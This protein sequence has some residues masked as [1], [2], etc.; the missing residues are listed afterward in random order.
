[1]ALHFGGFPRRV[2]IGRAFSAPHPRSTVEDGVKRE[3]RIPHERGALMEFLATCEPGSPVAVETVGNWYWIVD[4]IEEAG[5]EPR[6]VHAGK[7][8]LMLGMVNKTDKLDARG[9]NKLQRVGTLPVVWIPPGELRDVRELTR[10]RMVLVS[11]RTQLKNR[12]HSTLD[13]YGL[14]VGVSDLFGRKGR[15]LLERK[16][17]KLPPHTRQVTEVMLAQID[18]LE[19]KIEAIE[20]RMREVL[21]PRREVGLLQT[22]PGVGFILA[23]VI[24][25]EVGEVG[26]FPG[27]E[28]LASYAGMVP[29]VH[30]SGGKARYGRTR[31]DVNHYLKWAYSEAANVVARHW[32]KHPERHVSQLYGRVMMRRGHQKA[33]GAVGR[34]L[35]EATYWLL[36]K[37]EPYRDPALKWQVRKAGA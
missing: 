13:K 21:S 22:L 11:Q 35:A 8:K 5:F 10:T 24:W 15:E 19:E 17:T 14:K 12:I 3:G 20:G 31:K 28:H 23:T 27:P 6:L 32:R 18:L 2:P 4:E 36:R 33:I 16:L 25:L 29:R 9:L 30:S 26:R 1:M 37:G 34:H 7:A